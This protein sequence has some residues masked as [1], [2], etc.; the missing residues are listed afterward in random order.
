MNGA[1]EGD[2]EWIDSAEVAE[3]LGVTQHR[4]RQL[5]ARGFL[6][7]VRYGSRWFYRRHQVEVVANARDARKLRGTLGRGMKIGTT[8]TANLPRVPTPTPAP[9]PVP[10]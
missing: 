3:I 6:R 2:A 9:L 1:P 10:A 5:V 4:V 8:R 7:A